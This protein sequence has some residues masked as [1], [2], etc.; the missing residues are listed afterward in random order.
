MPIA[1]VRD[2]EEPPDWWKSVSSRPQ[3]LFPKVWAVELDPGRP[4]FAQC[5]SEVLENI[6]TALFGDNYFQD[7]LQQ[8]II[9]SVVNRRRLRP[10]WAMEFDPSAN[11]EQRLSAALLKL[12]MDLLDK[13]DVYTKILLKE[14]II[15][16][17]MDA[18]LFRKH[19]PLAEEEG[20]VELTTNNKPT[21]N[22]V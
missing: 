13:R 10:F 7:M 14:P 22:T 2:D 4:Y 5:L 6:K 9:I 15:I 8:P 17:V 11:F 1:E 19:I 16:S 12:R 20:V 18:R 21:A 3:G